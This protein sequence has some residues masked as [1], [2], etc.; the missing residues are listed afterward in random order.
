MGRTNSSG[1]ECN[2]C[3]PWVE[4]IK[5]DKKLQLNLTN[6]ACIQNESYKPVGIIDDVS[7]GAGVVMGMTNGPGT[8]TQ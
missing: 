8:T 4:T 3:G 2:G 6:H 7:V 1:G 5:Q